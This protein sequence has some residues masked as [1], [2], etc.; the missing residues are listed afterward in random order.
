M[1]QLIVGLMVAGAALYALWHFMPVRW[2]RAV[3]RRLG[4]RMTKGGCHACDDCG[5][6]AGPSVEM[7]KKGL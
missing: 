1:Q 3:A 5:A 2:R 4:V 6:C 7:N